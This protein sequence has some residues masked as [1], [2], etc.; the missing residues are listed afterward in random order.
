MSHG[1]FIHSSTDRCFVSFHILTVVNNAA[2]NTK[3]LMFFQISVLGSFGWIPKSG[4]AGSKSRSIF[5]FF[6]VPPYCFPQ[7]LHQS[8]FPP[9]VQKGSPFSTSS[10]GLVV[11][12]FII[13]GHSDRCEVIS[14]CGFDLHLS[15]DYWQWASFHMSV[16]HLYVLLGEVSIQVLCPFFNWVVWFFG[17]WVF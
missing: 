3:V 13:D 11:C 7:W 4:I 15:D 5:N 10:P 16:G 17:C 6:E 9:T 14:Y 8:A 2:M 1:C 12:L